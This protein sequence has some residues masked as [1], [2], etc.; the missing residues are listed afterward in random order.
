MS[1]PPPWRL[2]DTTECAPIDHR[3]LVDSKRVRIIEGAR[4]GEKTEIWILDP[5]VALP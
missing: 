4:E 2:L 1:F 5:D 3:L